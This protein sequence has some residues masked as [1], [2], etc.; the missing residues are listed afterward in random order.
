MDSIEAVIWGQNGGWLTNK[1]P[2]LS[3]FIAN[4]FYILFY[5]KDISI[6]ILSQVCI[7]I[8]FIYIFKIAKLFLDE[9]KS[10]LSVLLLEGVIYYNITS[11]EFNVNII[12]LALWPITIYYFYKALNE[13]KLYQWLLLGLF[14]GLNILNKYTCVYLFIS[15]FIYVI[16]SHETKKVFLNKKLYLGGLITLLCIFPHLYWLY[17]TD[18]IVFEYFKSRTV[19]N[20]K[21]G[22]LANIYYPIRFIIGQFLAGITTIIIFTISYYKLNKEQNN[23]KNTDKLFILCLGLLPILIAVLPSIIN[24]SKMK[25]MWGTPCLYM[26]TIILFAYFPFKLNDNSYKKIKASTYC[27]MVIFALFSTINI[28]ATKSIRYYFPKNQFIEDMTKYWVNETNNI[29]LKYVAG[30]IWYTAHMSLYQKDNPQVIYNIDKK[31]KNILND[32]ELA[33]NGLMIIGTNYQE[34]NNFQ[35][36]FNVLA[37]IKEYNFRTKNLL[38]KGKNYK[39]YYSIIL[40]TIMVENDK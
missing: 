10:V 8:G 7:L 39:L 38:N 17:K 14:I 24:G 18:F 33:N 26:L 5:G 30:D 34:V 37:P 27:V 36:Y 15:M 21:L 20:E 3:G 13:D 1:H 2:P 19:F 12:S 11:I 23:I 4:I 16:V 35:K 28:I 31:Y 29:Q 6:Y 9:E 22:L 40:P 25:S 32:D